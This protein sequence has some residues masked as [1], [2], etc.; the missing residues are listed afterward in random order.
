MEWVLFLCLLYTM[1]LDV[2]NTKEILPAVLSW[3]ANKI[4]SLFR[5]RCA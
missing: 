2:T 5:Y 3:Q 4:S 1:P